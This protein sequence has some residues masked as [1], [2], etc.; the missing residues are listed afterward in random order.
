MKWTTK[1][2]IYFLYSIVSFVFLAFWASEP[3]FFPYSNSWSFIAV[4]A[5]FIVALPIVFFSRR[6]DLYYELCIKNKGILYSQ[7]ACLFILEFII[8][9]N[10]KGEFLS[11]PHTIEV[12]TWML[13]LALFISIIRVIRPLTFEEWS[14]K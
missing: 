7:A 10:Q 3:S 5:I 8:Y 1:Q 6:K 9:M 11:S 12:F 14:N 2:I 4:F 13:T